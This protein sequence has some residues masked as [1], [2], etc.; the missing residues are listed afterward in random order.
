M[1]SRRPSAGRDGKIAL[2]S[3]SAAAGPKVYVGNFKDNTVSVIDTA[4]AKVVATVPVASGPHG[5]TITKDG[6][7][8]FVSGDTSSQVSVIDTATDRIAH[9]IEVGREPA[10]SA[11]TLD[12]R[13]LLVTVNGD[14]KVVF[15]DAAK[16]TVTG[17]VE[18]GKTAYGR[19]SP[20]GKLAYVTSQQ[21]GPVSSRWP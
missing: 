14:D 15:V 2:T 13:Q 11:L 18:V 4:T 10:C 21:T 20:N 12:G 17:L 7:W 5:M 9:T 19:R 6:K 16:H 8:V 3:G 1:Q